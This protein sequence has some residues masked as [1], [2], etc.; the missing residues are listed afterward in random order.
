MRSE[1]LLFL[2]NK[3]TQCDR[4][5]RKLRLVGLFCG[6]AEIALDHRARPW[7]RIGGQLALA[8]LK[9]SCH[10]PRYIERELSMPLP[11]SR[12]YRAAG[13]AKIENLKKA[14]AMKRCGL[15]A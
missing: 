4:F 1:Q 12:V 8:S 3:E 5:E 9:N 11:T 13:A 7:S 2:K 6:A 10:R 15:F 14:R